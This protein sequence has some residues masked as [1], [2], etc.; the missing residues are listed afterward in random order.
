MPDDTR[1]DRLGRVRRPEQDIF[2]P[3][4]PASPTTVMKVRVPQSLLDAMDAAA[5]DRGVT[6]SELVRDLLER[7]LGH[8]GGD[9][10]Q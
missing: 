6:R 9:L 10:P 7:G 1:R 2:Q 8:A 5:K 3:L 4:D